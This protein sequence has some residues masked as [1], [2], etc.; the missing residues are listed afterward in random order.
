[1]QIEITHF[2]DEDGSPLV[3]VPLTNAEASVT[4]YEADF[5]SLHQSGLDPRWRLSMGQVI[6]RG[7]G[8]VSVARLVANAKKGDKIQ[9]LDRNPC[10]LKRDNLVT[11]EGNAKSNA[12]DKLD[13]SNRSHQFLKE[14]VELKHIHQL[15]SWEA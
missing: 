4:L 1:M 6:E 7:R 3:S 5:N 2:L 12:M 8:R 9:Y 13:L 15:P 11:A 10:N 14:K